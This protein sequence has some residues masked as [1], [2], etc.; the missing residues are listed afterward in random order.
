MAQKR[1]YVKGT[2]TDGTNPDLDN[3]A[4]KNADVMRW[5]Q[6]RK[7]QTKQAHQK[8]SGLASLNNKTKLIRR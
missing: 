6:M 7:T 8:L 2:A 3:V 5:S 4:F 1:E